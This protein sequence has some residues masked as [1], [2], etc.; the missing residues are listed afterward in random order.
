MEDINLKKHLLWAVPLSAVLTAGVFVFA[1]SKQD[2]PQGAP[3]Q[4]AQDKAVA[5]LEAFLKPMQE[6]EERNR[7]AHCGK[8]R[9]GSVSYAGKREGVTETV[10]CDDGSIRFHYSAAADARMN[11]EWKEIQQALK[12]RKIFFEKPKPKNP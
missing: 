9:T 12:S 11:Q 2:R 5:E 1:P 3:T 10:R 7:A 6:R 4:T 8:R